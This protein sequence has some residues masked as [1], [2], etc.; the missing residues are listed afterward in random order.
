M[1]ENLKEILGEG[2]AKLI[3]LNRQ[4]LAVGY[5]YIQG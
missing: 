2:K 1:L 5:S 4:A 3:E